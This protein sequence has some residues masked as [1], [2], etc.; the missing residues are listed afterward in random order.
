MRFA[1]RSIATAC[2]TS[3]VRRPQPYFV[4]RRNGEGRA[5]SFLSDGEEK[6]VAESK[7]ASKFEIGSESDE[8]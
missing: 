5:A 1:A 2:D 7:S 4:S 8:H 6:L 3:W